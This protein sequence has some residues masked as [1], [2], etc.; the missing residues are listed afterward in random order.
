MPAKIVAFPTQPQRGKQ[1]KKPRMAMRADNRYTK[2]FWYTDKT[3]ERKEK[4]VYGSTQGEAEQ[5]KR[6]FLADV[7]AGLRVDKANMIVS[8]WIDE[9]LANYKPT[10]RG[11]TYRNKE[12]D[13]QVIR[14][15]IGALKMRE[16]EPSDIKR[17][18]SQ[19]AGMA[20]SYIKKLKTSASQLFNAAVDDHI[21]PYSP[22]VRIALPRGTVSEH[23]ELER[24]E[25]DIVCDHWRGHWFGIMAMIMMFA[26][27]RPGEAIAL[28]DKAIDLT[29]DI[30]SIDEAI[31]FDIN[32]PI[33]GGPKTKAGIR[34]VPIFIPLK[35]ALTEYMAGR[36]PGRLVEKQTGGDM[37]KSAFKRA[38]QSYIY[39]LE[40]RLNGCYK[41]W[42]KTK[43]PKDYVWKEI[44]FTAYDLRHTFCTMC[45]DAGVDLKT[46]A[47]WMGHGDE[48]VTLKVYS[49]LSR[50]RKQASTASMADYIKSNFKTSGSQS[51]SQTVE[52]V[53]LE[54]QDP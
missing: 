17:I 32:E 38:W 7:A 6:N 23:R 52:N 53:K 54:P 25:R 3:G 24:W 1:D 2:H 21:I 42:V 19:R 48:T 16:V 10:V 30:I 46:T 4:F 28:T 27:C 51:G 36:A 8:D 9:F 34:N 14:E 45:Y 41:R 40:R 5:N 15:D 43:K 39:Y 22:C 47:Q 18:L 49:H 11:H 26:S 13:M 50:I 31:S 37:T 33:I 44:T 35:T 29:K 20:D 12:I